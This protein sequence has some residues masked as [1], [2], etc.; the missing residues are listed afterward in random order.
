M[1]RQRRKEG[2]ETLSGPIY[3]IGVNKGKNRENCY[4]MRRGKYIKFR[5]NQIFGGKILFCSLLSGRRINEITENKRTKTLSNRGGG[6][7][8]RSTHM[9]EREKFKST[10]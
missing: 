1:Y 2:E 8:K 7:N 5:G 9:R 4:K 6:D 3:K 10:E